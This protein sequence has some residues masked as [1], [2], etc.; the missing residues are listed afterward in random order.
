MKGMRLSV[1]SIYQNMRYR[2]LV[3]RT[4]LDLYSLKL[5][6]LI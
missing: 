4:K 3:F 2:A 1:A 5:K 6:E